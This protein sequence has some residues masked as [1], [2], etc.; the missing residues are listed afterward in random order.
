MKI[1]LLIIDPQNDFCNP[2]GSLY[3]PGADE[4][5]K[6]LA[7][8]VH[9]MKDKIDDIHVTLDSHR[10]V[11]IAHPIWWKDASGAHPGPVAGIHTRFG[12]STA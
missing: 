8:L 9:R 11:D 5:V 12:P 3:V 4:D 6:R 2:N 10:K 1:H 7:G